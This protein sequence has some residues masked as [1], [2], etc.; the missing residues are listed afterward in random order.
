MKMALGVP[1]MGQ[2]H[3]DNNAELLRNQRGLTLV[4]LKLR[5]V[6]AKIANSE[7]VGI[8]DNDAEI[9]VDACKANAQGEVPFPPTPSQHGSSP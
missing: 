3:Y 2:Q 8:N 6:V 4:L 1:G 5:T 7:N 9:D